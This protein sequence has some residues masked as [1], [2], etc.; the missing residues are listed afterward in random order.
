MVEIIIYYLLK[1]WGFNSSTSIERGLK[2]YG[3]E[4]ISHNVEYSLHPIVKEYDV[5]VANDGTSIIATKI[6][7]ALEN[8]KD[9]GKGAP[10]ACA[11]I[12]WGNDYEKFTYL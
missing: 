2:E 1:M 5:N 8:G 6:L 12:Y 11:M 3:N 4:D 9:V 7:K 10:M